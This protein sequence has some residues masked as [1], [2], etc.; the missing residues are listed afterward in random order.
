MRQRLRRPLVVALVLAM[1]ATLGGLET[2]RRYES[3]QSV[4]ATAGEDEGFLDRLGRAARNLVNGGPGRAR[5]ERVIAGLRLDQKPKPGVV[6]K[7]AKRVKE[8]TGRRTAT[9]QVFQM[10]DGR[11]QAEVSAAPRFYQDAKGA[12]QPIDTTISAAKAG[13]FAAANTSNTFTSR[14]GGTTGNL[15]RFELDGQQVTLGLAGAPRLVTPT[16]KGDTVTYAGILDGV[17]LSYEVTA[18]AL[19][20][21]M[22]LRSAAAASTFT[23]SMD[24]GTLKVAQREDGSIEFRS[25]RDNRV[26][27]VMPAPFMFDAKAEASSPYGYAYSTKV[28]QALRAD[29]GRWAI[30]VTADKGWLSD[31]KRV[32]PVTVD[33]TIKIQPTKD[34][35]KDAMVMRD[36]PREPYGSTWNLSVGTTSGGAARSL[37]K[38]DLTSIPANTTIDSATLQ[39]YYDQT[40]TTNA[41]DVPIEVREVTKDWNEDTVNWDFINTS[42]GDGAA[43][44]VQ[45]DDVETDKIAMKGAWPVST[46][47]IV[48][49]GINGTYRYNKDTV[50]G[51]TFTWTPTLPEDGTYTVEEHHVPYSDRSQA[52]EFTVTYDG[53]SKMTPINQ[54]QPANHDWATLG[55]Y[56]F[57]AGTAGKVVLGDATVT[58][59]V[60]VI[61][62]AVRFTKAGGVKKK[63]EANVWN[64]FPA[65]NL[66]QKW[67]NGA[68]NF[69]FM[70]KAVD[71]ERLAHGGPRY[72]AA[73][74]AFNGETENAPKLIINYGNPG[75]VVETPRT[76]YPT[77]AA[78][79]WSQYQGSDLAEYQVH[80]SSSPN[81][82]PTAATLVAPVKG[83]TS[84]TD[85]TATPTPA[86]STDP[87]GQ[88]YYYQAAVKTTGGQVVPSAAVVAKLPKSG[89]VLATIQASAD[90]TVSSKQ[91]TTNLN[92]L[93]GKPLLNVGNSS[94]DYTYARAL[95]R[96]D[97]SSI[98]SNAR[99]LSSSLNLW[100]SGTIVSAQMSNYNVHALT[101]PFDPATVTWQ[102]ATAT[103]NWTT[104]GGDYNTAVAGSL[105]NF[106]QDD[107]PKWRR[108]TLDSTVQNWINGT[109]TNNGLLVKHTDE[110]GRLKQNTD[111]IAS[112]G[113]DALR[114]QLQVVYTVPDAVQTYHAPTTPTVMTSDGTYSIPVTLANP[115]DTPWLK[116]DWALSY[117]WTLPNG[118]P[119]PTAGASLRTALPVDLAPIGSA[120]GVSSVDVTA[121]VK[122][123]APST[124][125]NRRNNYTLKWEL[126]KADGTKLTDIGPLTQDI[127][128]EEPTSDQLG[129]EKY[130][131]YAGISTGA[132]SS[133]SNNLYA[134]N[135]VW[136]YNALSNP[137]RGS[138]STFVRLAYNSLDTSNSVAGHGWSLQATAVQRLGSP[139]DFHPNLNPTTVTLTD[140]D[141]TSHRFTWDPATS[142]W[143]S[144]KGVH[145]Y[146]QKV[147]S[148]DCKPNTQ[149]RRA[150][151]LI[152]PDRTQFYYDCEGFPTSVVDNNDNE[153]V[154]T[155]EE[156]RS[157]NKPTKFLRYLTDP[158]GRQTLTLDYYVKGQDYDYIDDTDWTRKSATNLTNPKII[159]HVSRITDISGRKLTFTYTDK[160]LLGELI[161]GAGFSQPKVFEFA[162]DATQGNKNVKLVKVTD[163]RD[164][165]TDLYYNYPQTGDD[166]QFHWTTKSYRDRSL[167]STQ[168]AYTDPDG[169]QL[170]TINATVTDAELHDT[171]YLMDGYGR[172]TQVTNAK[173]EITKLE[174]DDDHNVNK[175][176]ENN[177]AAWSWTF[178]AK[179]GYP[180][181]IKDAEA[182][183]NGTNGTVLTYDGQLNGYVADLASRTSPQGRKWTFGHTATG[184]VQWV[185]DPVG[186]TTED[187]EDYKTLYSYDAYGQL[188][189]VTDANGHVTLS[190]DYDANGLPK[191]VTDALENA[192]TFVYDERGQVTR[193]TDAEGKR[194]SQEYDVFGRPLASTMPVNQAEGRF[195]TTPAPE[196][197][198]NDNVVNAVAPNG[199]V[200][201]VKYDSSDQVEHT[202]A[203]ADTIDGTRPKTSYD[204]D[205]VGNVRFVTE[206]RGN[207]TT[208][209][210]DDFVTE[211]VYDKIYQLTSTIDALDGRTSFEYDDVGNLVKVVDPRKNATADPDDFTAKQAYDLNHR[212]T[213]ST[214]AIGKTTSLGYDRDGLTT[215]R[216]DQE[217]NKVLIN[218]DE[219]GLQ[220]EVK[221]PHE[222]VDGNINY[223]TTEY[224]YDEVGN[225]TKVV[226]PRG[227][228]TTNDLDDFAQITVY[229]K[230]NRVKEQ[231]QPYDRDDQYY[232]VPE[233]TV[234][235]YD[236]VGN[237]T[238][239]SQPPAGKAPGVDG[240][241]V[242]TV[243]SYLDNG[244]MAT[245]TDP[246][247]VQAKF[248]YNELGRQTKRTLT[249]ADGALSR[250]MTW[251]YYPD[252]K[253]KS[254]MDNGAPFGGHALM[255][256]NSDPEEAKAFG[257]TPW[258]T[259]TSGSGYYGPD[260]ATHA[261]GTGE[262][263]FE[264]TMPPRTEDA[265][266][267]V[268]VR[269]PAVEGA[270][271]DAKY[272]V[273]SAYPADPVTVT[274]DQTQRAGEWISLG[275]YHVTPG[276]APYAVKLSDQANGTVVADTVKWVITNTIDPDNEYLTFDYSYDINGNLTRIHDGAPSTKIDYYENTYDGLNRTAKTE[277]VRSGSV[278][279]TATYRYDAN[280]NLTRRTYDARIDT[281]EHDPRDLLA[282]VTNAASASDLEPEVTSYTYTAR[283]QVL[284]QTK[285]LNYTVDYTYYSDGLLRHQIDKQGGL[286]TTVTEHD[287]TYDLNGNR[288]TD[289]YKL[290]NADNH[291]A[292]LNDER[293]YTY[294]PRNRVTEV[295]KYGGTETYQY[296]ANSNII[297]ERQ[298][299]EL[300]KSTNYSHTYDRNRLQSTLTRS[301]DGIGGSTSESSTYT[302]DSFGRMTSADGDSAWNW[303]EYDGFDRKVRRATYANQTSSD[304]TEFAYD[305]FHRT[306][307]E[308]RTRRDG[309]N[310]ETTSTTAFQYLGASDLVLSE[311]H[312]SG[313]KVTDYRYGLN[314]DRLS[315]D[316]TGES[317]G[318]YYYSYNPHGD[319][320]AITIPSGQTAATY[321]YT[322]YGRD[323]LPMFTG[324]DK[325][326]PENPSKE[327]VNAYR[328][329]AKRWDDGGTYD[330]GFRDY[331][332]TLARFLTP[333]VYA[334]GMA[335]LSLGISPATANRYAF[336]GGNPITN[337]EIDGHYSGVDF[338]EDLVNGVGATVAFSIAGVLSGPAM[339]FDCAAQ[340][341]ACWQGVKDTYNSAVDNPWGYA[342]G[343]WH[344]TWDPIEGSW[345][346]GEEGVAVGM[347]I[348]VIVGL[349]YGGKG[350]NKALKATKAAKIHTAGRG[351]RMGESESFL[352]NGATVRYSE[353]ATAIGDDDHTMQNFLRSRGAAGHDAILHGD[354]EGNFRVNGMITH[355]QQVADAILENPS[356]RRGDPINLVTCHGACGAAQDLGNI[357]GVPV[358]ASLHE[359]DLHPR[360][361]LLREW[362][363]GY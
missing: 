81:F 248:E 24:A 312:D 49:D 55:T 94:V 115:T 107:P 293:T 307:Q 117:T 145:L 261:P 301:Y 177:T 96:F 93:G 132:G 60:A 297:F 186:N 59:N 237:L 167:S 150:W 296:D 17:D 341:S 270:A 99:V 25:P 19:K 313:K 302:Y 98:P 161:D 185:V 200:T 245:S 27:L 208:A 18:T 260:Y 23:F 109:V 29:G 155:Y 46:S 54:Q 290:M 356:Y 2:L 35:A 62:D 216:T 129:L 206:P 32:W 298:Q 224:K 41:Y 101:R 47:T 288:A 246:F 213:V 351:A 233:P 349:V 106:G 191:A 188:A 194:F 73:E 142:E 131:A 97:T 100:S 262:N 160:G 90:A 264:W 197:D 13:G 113:T 336:A 152:R 324:A 89:Q 31:S 64:S 156:R 329:N 273:T 303:Y 339:A 291:G 166:P 306:T 231:I 277:E 279:H 87:Y 4:T 169:P 359:V 334:S 327:P 168:F 187:T 332:P 56:P 184:D 48:K 83:A 136:S 251:D 360:T 330:M 67:V 255:V 259:S 178:D 358:N 333:D 39:M 61:A 257:P 355:P 240:L 268:F 276:T 275:K 243:Y 77:G 86:N 271:T 321:G 52:A 347:G 189:S 308:T 28:T 282:K 22:V 134:G 283:K 357:L 342:K 272:T 314:G 128:V 108:W 226:S 219:R 12:W 170:K 340:A 37:V 209:D 203:P 195:I 292:Y 285:A 196:Y 8:L 317:A 354:K 68:D 149:E 256:D 34:A 162:Y 133:L 43:T 123:P 253:L 50:A 175:L 69:G 42:M 207:L 38:F 14:F 119:V 242:D 33:P 21:R 322:A 122:A 181:E 15:A 148:L 157:N 252:G 66:V 222:T 57:K 228:A 345:E 9:T 218:Y 1:V 58:S 180:T 326:D 172:P 121:Q 5:P 331:S 102:K 88:V 201:T 92:T 346:A 74:D 190:S 343:M 353:T 125:G 135:T 114:P 205:K 202:L 295:I 85:T 82:T 36:A 192:T 320:E 40:H 44:V 51:D 120:S 280:S 127:A 171:T 126:S 230:L 72:E 335:D 78:L 105:G 182:V 281:F 284:R 238:K 239:V 151:R 225:Q 183:K 328:F 124:D 286:G 267:E 309:T 266:A 144:P 141:G 65:T 173:T 79:R 338:L 294:D 53:G 348:G 352:W 210:P 80:R 325:P 337:I 249:G 217:G 75:V 3:D 278:A 104:A 138:L 84:F 304:V 361:G 130:Y 70:L 289:K 274:V 7:P 153:L 71:E 143:K 300:N 95:L 159:D 254:H 362:E 299:G 146:L 318:E 319:V 45:V 235:D 118:D 227:V 6:K 112:E 20:E 140:G 212:P 234:Y 204:Y 247:G 236:K 265:E 363:N 174:W 250:V 165:T 269:Y 198:A 26:L 137:S 244:W 258:T 30:D 154:F 164:H 91:N 199:A 323:D 263:R 310:P 215:S 110:P 311:D 193:I 229:D 305:P 163:P 63:D 147:T 211:Y 139:L 11:L 241:R 179:T 344:D 103:T 220:S 315:Q 350:L 287:V 316:T 214:D 223:R 116:S 158:A 111:F 232:N 176:I 76:L 10:S 221:V 16:W